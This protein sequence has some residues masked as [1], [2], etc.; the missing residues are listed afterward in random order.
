MKNRGECP[1]GRRSLGFIMYS[2]CV[3]FSCAGHASLSIEGSVAES[4][5]AQAQS[6]GAPLVSEGD[7]GAAELGGSAGD[8]DE[9]TVGDASDVGAGGAD[10][11]SAGSGDVLPPEPDSVAKRAESGTR[12]C[13]SSADCE[14]SLSCSPSAGRERLA[15]LAPCETDAD[16]K[17]SERCFAHPSIQKS[18]FQRC[19]ESFTQCE[20]QFDC[21]DYYR[22]DEYSCIPS[23][24]VRSW[25]PTEPAGS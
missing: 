3:A 1:A 12:L 25:P 4:G 6:A 18:C 2:V 16:C 13:E 10:A 17:H 8:A 22:R 23:E 5:T 14:S 15:C 11:S 7:A 9:P 19:D 24:W 21:A 20:F